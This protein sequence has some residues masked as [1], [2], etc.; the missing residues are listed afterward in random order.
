MLRY[1]NI[2]RIHIELTARC[3]ASCP[4]C[5]RNVYGGYAIP[6]LDKTEWTASEF[7][8][9]FTPKFLSQLQHILF[10][11]NY[12]DPGIARELLPILRYVTENSNAQVTVH[13]NGGMRS[14][15]FWYA[16]GTVLRKQGKVVWSFDGLWDTN[17]IYRKGVD[18]DRA[19]ANAESYI[20]TGARA[21]WEMLVFKHNEHQVAECEALSKSSGFHQFIYKRA[22]GFEH[23]P[24]MKTLDKSGKLCYTISEPSKAYANIA[25]T[26]TGRSNTRDL[27][28][29][30]YEK[31]LDRQ[32][33][34]YANTGFRHEH[35][36][37]IHCETQ[38]N[39][40]IY[41]DSAGTVYP[42]CHIGH[43]SQ[44]TA[45][46][47]YIQNRE[48]LR[49]R[50]GSRNL[51]CKFNDLQ[52]IVDSDYFRRI[53]ATWKLPTDNQNRIAMCSAMCA[54]RNNKMQSVYESI[55]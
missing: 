22:L 26:H 27:T 46:E 21:T 15:E 17:H 8:A 36:Q 1:K 3:Q 34:V 16:V 51:S 28:P 23:A 2:Q 18:W 12:G 24:T 45:G 20:S 33:T 42:C 50:F 48:W 9:S 5:P 55:R 37:D 29:D 41:V 10:C 30:E 44:H 38:H 49:E 35:T 19:W 52:D 13:T 4:G 6:D 7:R 14:T 11:G 43:A 54:K 47:L 40:E 25:N 31:L 32:M 39:R 53:Q